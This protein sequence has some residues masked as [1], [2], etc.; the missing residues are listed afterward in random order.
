MRLGA[1]LERLAKPVGVLAERNVRGESGRRTSARGCSGKGVRSPGFFRRFKCQREPLEL[2]RTVC[3]LPSETGHCQVVI[4]SEAAA[5]RLQGET[6]RRAIRFPRSFLSWASS[7]LTVWSL[8]ES[9]ECLFGPRSFA[10]SVKKWPGVHHRSETRPPEGGGMAT[11]AKNAFIPVE[12]FG[13][14]RVVLWSWHFAHPRES[15]KDGADCCGDFTE[16]LVASLIPRGS[17]NGASAGTSWPR[18]VPVWEVAVPGTEHF[19]KFVPANCS[20]TNRS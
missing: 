8:S 2:T 20:L 15:Q 10:L 11:V 5:P 19:C 4:V 6:R 12:V 7:V 13:G 9:R 16:H 18:R 1:G 3:R 14:N 17:V